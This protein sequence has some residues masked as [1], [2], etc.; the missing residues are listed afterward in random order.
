MLY[1]SE[2]WTIKKLSKKNDEQ[3][4]FKFQVL[5]LYCLCG[6][7]CKK[8]RNVW[9][10]HVMRHKDLLK[11]II[12]KAVEGKNRRERPRLKYLKRV[13]ENQN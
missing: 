6:E 10:G 9:I 2:S 12:E 5:V 4:S 11:L 3:T 7:Y 13:M 8:L 1:G